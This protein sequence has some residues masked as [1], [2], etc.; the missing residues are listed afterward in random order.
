MLNKLIL[1]IY[2]NHPNLFRNSY[3]CIFP[4]NNIFKY[5]ILLH[6]A[7]IQHK[8]SKIIKLEFS[9]ICYLFP[10]CR[11]SICYFYKNYTKWIKYVSLYIL[12][13]IK[14]WFTR[15]ILKFY[16][17]FMHVGFFLYQRIINYFKSLYLQLRISKNILLNFFYNVIKTY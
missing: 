16:E 9:D 4:K 17:H 15:N 6:R 5:R 13:V 2:K 3:P 12:S 11:K 8:R 14:Y 10:W 1:N 7:V